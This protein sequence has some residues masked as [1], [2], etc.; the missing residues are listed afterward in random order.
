[1]AAELAATRPSITLGALVGELTD[2]RR[3]LHVMYIEDDPHTDI[4]AVF[5]WSY[6]GLGTEAAR[7]FRLLGLHPGPDIS[8]PAAA[9]LAGLPHDQTRQLLDH[10]TRAHLLTEHAPGRFEFHDL[11]RAYWS[12]N[13]VPV[14]PWEM[15]LCYHRL[16]CL[17]IDRYDPLWSKRPDPCA[18]A[19][20]AD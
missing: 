11:L 17:S 18:P 9:S 3:R 14:I 6:R 1:M 2:Q 20:D 15:F 13:I 5:S 12:G 8:I 16:K 10:L 19:A 4:S 7:L